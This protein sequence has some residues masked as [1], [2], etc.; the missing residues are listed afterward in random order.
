MQHLNFFNIFQNRYRKEQEEPAK[1]DDHCINCGSI[2]VKVKQI[3][4]IY[5][6]CCGER[7]SV[8]FAIVDFRQDQENCLKSKELPPEPYFRC[9]RCLE[10]YQQCGPDYE[11]NGRETLLE[12]TICEAELHAPIGYCISCWHGLADNGQCFNFQCSRYQKPNIPK[13]TR[14]KK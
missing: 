7:L 6:Q 13:S 10:E 9:S 1:E 4:G 2:L 12:C 8:Y 3:D 11:D 14:K 5:S